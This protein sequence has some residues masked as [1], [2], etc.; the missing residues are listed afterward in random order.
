MAEL[1]GFYSISELGTFISWDKQ[2]VGNGFLSTC[3]QGHD[4]FTLQLFCCPSLP[5]TELGEGHLQTSEDTLRQTCLDL[6]QGGG[7]TP[8]PGQLF[9]D[10]KQHVAINQYNVITMFHINRTKQCVTFAF[11]SLSPRFSHIVAG[12]SI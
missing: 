1:A 12:I 3:C 10:L 7:A 5:V 9:R 8:L 4:V 2:S 11:G 6:K